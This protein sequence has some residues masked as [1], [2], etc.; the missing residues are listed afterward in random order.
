MSSGRISLRRHPIAIGAVAVVALILAAC[1]GIADETTSATPGLA[2]CV[3]DGQGFTGGATVPRQIFGS[4]GPGQSLVW[5]VESGSTTGDPQN[6]QMATGMP[7][8][9][10]TILWGEG[11]GAGDN[12]LTVECTSSWDVYDEADPTTLWHAGIIFDEIPGLGTNTYFCHHIVM[13]TS[14]EAAVMKMWET[15]WTYGEDYS[16]PETLRAILDGELDFPNP[17]TYLELPDTGIGAATVPPDQ[18][19]TDGTAVDIEA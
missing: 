3:K 10:V 14:G 18:W 1:G 15:Y 8:G 9:V 2:D 17:V 19:T 13:D 11:A 16:C 12:T 6:V 4:Y 5:D 7:N